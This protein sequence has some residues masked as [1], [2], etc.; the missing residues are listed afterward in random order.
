MTKQQNKKPN[1]VFVITDDQGYGD[2]A[3]H[4][5]PVISTPNLDELHDQCVRLENYHV[6]PTCSPTRAGLMTGRYCNAT[7]VWHT[8]GG[9]S[10]LRKDEMTMADV[11]GANGYA[12]GIFGKWHLGDNYPFRPHDRGF[13]TALYHADGAIGT[14]PDYWGNDYF[15]D[16]Y[17]DRG[18][19]R[20]FEGYCTDVWFDQA[21]KFI[22]QNAKEGR[23]FFCYLPTNAPHSPYNVPDSYS[24]PYRGKVPDKRA[25]F[26]GMI[27]CIDENV[28][29]LRA[30]LNE[31]GLA[32]NTIFIF[33]TDNGT[34]GGC[35]VDENHFVTDGYNAHMRGKKN[36]EY[37]GGHRVPAFIYWPG[38]GLVGGRQVWRVTANIDILPTL[39][40]LCDLRAPEVMRFHGQ[41]IA[42][43]LVG[44]NEDWPDRVLVTDSQRVENPIKWRKSAVMTDRW[45]LVNGKELYDM[46]A[47][48]GQQNDVSGEHPDLV[49]KL[50][51]E[52]ETWWRIVS[53]RFDEYCYTII[54]TEHETV[55]PITSQD[56]HG[57]DHAW[58]QQHIREGKVCNGFW[59]IELARDGEYSF[60]LRRW[61]READLPMGAGI[62][63]E[64]KDWYTG[65][66]ALA[67][68]KVSIKVGDH[69]QSAEV[70]GDKK[71]VTFKFKLPAGRTT[72]QTHMTDA[73]GADRGA[74]Y[75]YVE[76]KD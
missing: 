58:N 7:G 59:A 47:D 68:Q 73:D 37:D 71:C 25:N 15:D 48:P 42:P 4:G 41:S 76:R 19:H 74:Y 75:V 21:L 18:E 61:P 16:V 70:D 45:R 14:T 69:E 27:T 33:M 5:N 43:L 29:R 72:F 2:L 13:A 11:F 20:Q 60:E 63:G 9:R 38:G 32:E 67:I 24:E 55:S 46:G 44:K 1:F 50:R 54:G 64:I 31:L 30:K 22:E 3:C 66:N 65:G 39:M 52:Y 12:T 8:L 57:E 35:D 62:Q 28:G 23:P 53:E 49:E 6:G 36:S 17:F 10:Q 51:G 34:S 40:E 26:Y 56:W